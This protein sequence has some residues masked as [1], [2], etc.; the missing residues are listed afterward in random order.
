VAAG[1]QMASRR[2]LPALDGAACASPTHHT[3]PP[4]GLRPRSCHQVGLNKTKDQLGIAEER[5]KQLALDL[6]R[7][8]MDLLAKTSEGGGLCGNEEGW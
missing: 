3:P 5:V 7:T 2:D 8:Q 1:E 6:Q 4:A